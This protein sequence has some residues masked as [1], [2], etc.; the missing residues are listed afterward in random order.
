MFIQTEQ[1]PNPATLKFIPG[2][3]VLEQ[4]SADFPSP[5]SAARSPLA[6]RLFQ[7]DGV[8]AVFLGSD[9]VTVTKHPDREWYLMKPAVLGVIME[10][11]TAGRPTLLAGDAA[12]EAAEEDDEVVRTIKELLDTRVRPA[13]AQDGGDIVFHG[14]EEGVVYLHMQGSC[15]GCPSSTATLKMGIENMLRHY[16]PEVLEVRAVA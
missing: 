14:F 16:V 11:F 15:A 12:A 1:T 2:K 8:A 3:V 7:V 4:G 9:F 10:H 13:V 6:E 5:E